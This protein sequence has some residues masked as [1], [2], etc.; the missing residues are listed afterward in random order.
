MLEKA[1]SIAAVLLYLLTVFH[2]A[3]IVLLACWDP[4]PHTVMY[5]FLSHLSMMNLCTQ[6]AQS[7]S[8]C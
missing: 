8:C 1:L 4:W 7:P 3:A 2:N 5:L 6:P